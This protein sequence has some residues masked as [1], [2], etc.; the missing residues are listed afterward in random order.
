MEDGTTGAVAEALCEQW[1]QVLDVDV[2]PRA[3][4][5]QELW[6]ALR[7]G[8]YTLA[9][10]NLEAPGN[11]AECFLM[12]W[13][14]DSYD[15]VANYENSAYDTLMSIIARASDGTA[16]MGCLHDAE[17]LLLEDQVLNPLYTEGTAWELREGLTGACRDARGWFDFSNVTVQT[18]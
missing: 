10:V 3:V 18:A 6:S 8:E 4:T 5:S 12:D 16:R 14:S 13:I 11:D 2:T 17:A 15:N 9:G 7:S 1:S